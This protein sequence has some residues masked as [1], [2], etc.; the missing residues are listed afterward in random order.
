MGWQAGHVKGSVEREGV[1]SLE[2]DE[3]D[4][5]GLA[6]D[7][8]ADHRAVRGPDDQ[9]TFPVSRLAAVDRVERSVVHRQHRRVEP[10]ASLAGAHLGSSVVTVR[11]Q[12]R[13]RWWAHDRRARQG[14]V[15]LVDRAVDRL[16]AQP[17]AGIVWVSDAQFSRDVLRLHRS[18]RAQ[19]L[20]RAAAGARGPAAGADERTISARLLSR[21]SAWRSPIDCGPASRST[22]SRRAGPGAPPPFSREIHRHGRGERL[23]RPFEAQRVSARSGPRQPRGQRIGLRSLAR[24]ARR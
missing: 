23:Y 15:R 13:A 6:F 7:Q 24:A 11:A 20:G 2:V 4:D 16:R 5:A 18:L 1:G 12:R 17:H 21:T 14:R 8:G 10:L 22:R 9:V 3:V 19:R